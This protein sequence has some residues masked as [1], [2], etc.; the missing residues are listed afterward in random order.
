MKFIILISLIIHLGSSHAQKPANYR[1]GFDV[2]GLSIMNYGLR[3]LK[4]VPSPIYPDYYK[5]YNTESYNLDYQSFSF[6]K[7]LNFGFTVNII[8]TVYD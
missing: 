2:S 6:S 5:V 4:N 8:N 3:D 7:G 1:F